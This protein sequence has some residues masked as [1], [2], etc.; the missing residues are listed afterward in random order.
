[1][2]KQA[3]FIAG[4]ENIYFPALVTLESIKEYNNNIF[5]MFMCFDGSKLT[6]YMQKILNKHSIKF[7]D[8][9]ELKKFGVEE[10]FSV[11]AENHWPIDIFYNYVLPVYLNELGY[12]YSYKVDYDI[13]CIGKYIISEIE[14]S[15]VFFSGWANKINLEKERVEKET[16]KKLINE[17]MISGQHID[18]MN[19]GFVGFNNKLYSEQKVFDKFT[20]AYSFLKTECPNAKL[21]EQIAFALVIESTKGKFKKFSEAYNHRVL[22]TRG[23][24]D[25]FEFDTKNIHFIT[26][27]KPWK[28]LEKDKIKWFIFNHGSHMYLYRNLWLEF[29]SKIDGFEFFCMETPLTTKQLVGME[30]H[31]VRCFNE[32]IKLLKNVN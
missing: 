10:K 31:I 11:M 5:D 1:M 12:E 23:S 9:R 24:D 18:Y 14:P 2:K 8:S 27:F 25:N 21:L 17:N 19:V 15:D 22:S 28:K 4:D 30:M 3:I 13:L 16:I 32:K 26:K 20:E 7:I 29:A 6:P